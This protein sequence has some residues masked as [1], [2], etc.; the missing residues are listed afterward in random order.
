MRLALSSVLA[1]LTVCACAS[2]HAAPDPA[3]PTCAF[4]EVA[5]RSQP[6][7]KVG[8]WVE[9][10]KRLTPETKVATEAEA[11]AEVCKDRE[12]CTD[13][14]I[15]LCDSEYK[16]TCYVR[17]SGKA[18]AWYAF[19]EVFD[20]ADN[21]LELKVALSSDRR[22]AHLALSQEILGRIED[23]MCETDAEGN[24]D[25]ISAT[26]SYGWD[27]ADLIID[28]ERMTLTWDA[29]VSDYD[30]WASGVERCKHRHAIT[31]EG[32]TFVRTSCVGKPERFEE[33][34]LGACTVALRE[35]TQKAEAEARR[36]AES[37][38]ANAD[39]KRTQALVDEGRKLTKAKD[40]AG[41][42][43][44]FD[45]AL[46]ISSLFATALSGR[47]YAR[48]QRA[49]GDDLALA[50][51]DFEEALASEPRDKKFRGAVFFNLGLVCEKQKKA[52]EAKEFF[53]KSHAQN[54]TDATRKKLGL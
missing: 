18:V 53:E 31:F 47:G 33:K 37:A 48:L 32:T 12:G 22:F 3:T 17:G 19:E 27:H 30:E 36:A 10:A 40:Y 16:T 20:Q 1:P 34:D 24:T 29:Y 35:T 15:G 42:V 51:A 11:I 44:A 4:P 8:G 9:L 45:R 43:Q 26:G 41:A 28:L 46:A 2:A 39:A 25:C 21:G 14:T 52:A 23:A 13:K 7:K 54:P 6:G 5:L 49:K 50:R 38:A